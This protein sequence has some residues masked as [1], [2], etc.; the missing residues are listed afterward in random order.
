MKKIDLNLKETTPENFPFAVH[1]NPM[2]KRFKNKIGIGL[3]ID[4]KL[5]IPKQD[6]NETS[7]EIS[8]AELL[9]IYLK[10][11]KQVDIVIFYISQFNYISDSLQKQIEN[12]KLQ[13]AHCLVINNKKEIILK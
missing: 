3:I 8:S 1:F 11:K 12:L 5:V 10:Y 9:R 7:S 13:F 6:S 4:N 2:R